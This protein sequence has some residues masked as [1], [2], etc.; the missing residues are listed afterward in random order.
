MSLSLGLPIKTIGNKFD[1]DILP[2]GGLR[3]L[4][5]N[6]GLGSFK[7]HRVKVR[8]KIDAIAGNYE[9]VFSGMPDIRAFEESHVRVF[10]VKRG[11]Y[12]NLAILLELPDFSPV[13]L[14][15][16]MFG[17]TIN[18]ITLLRDRNQTLAL[19]VTSRNF[20]N[21]TQVLTAHGS[22]RWIHR[23]SEF[24]EGATLLVTLPFPKRKALDMKIQIFPDGLG[25]SLPDGENLP[26]DLALTAISPIRVTR[27][28]RKDYRLYD[29]LNSEERTRKFHQ[30]QILQF[31]YFIFNDTYVAAAE[32]LNAMEEEL[33]EMMPEP[34]VSKTDTLS[35]F[36]AEESHSE[37]GRNALD[38]FFKRSERLS[39]VD[40]SEVK[41]GKNKDSGLSVKSPNLINRL[42]L[43]RRRRFDVKYVY[44]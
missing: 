5:E 3:V 35:D 27:V 30:I 20:S 38:M 42:G 13:T 8:G 40:Q 12:K 37:G 9:I 10:V 7:L 23:D 39:E 31:R 25:F 1:V 26:A 11:T 29:N 28:D 43:L 16:K 17:P 33:K 34:I 2:T 24:I 14:L 21:F 41:E 22:S 18:K 19:F 15:K 36:M 44:D 6:I 32:Q 4:L